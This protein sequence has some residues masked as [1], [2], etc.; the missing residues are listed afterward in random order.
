VY[1]EQKVSADGR[2]VW[3]V[4]SGMGTQWAHMGRDLMTLDCFRESVVRSDALLR[5]YGVDLIELLMNSTEET[6]N[7]VVSSFASIVSVQVMY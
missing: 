5:P 3:F 6:F 7:D 2:P 4:F 1:G